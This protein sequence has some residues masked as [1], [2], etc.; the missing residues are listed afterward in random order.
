MDN[1]SEFVPYGTDPFDSPLLQN[2]IE[3][4]P[5]LVYL[6]NDEPNVLPQQQNDPVDVQQSNVPFPDS[7][8]QNQFVQDN[9][10]F[11][12]EGEIGNFEV[13]P[14]RRNGKEPLIQDQLMYGN[15]NFFN[16][17]GMG[18]FETGPWTQENQSQPANENMGLQN[19]EEVISLP[20]WPPI[21]RPFFCSCCHV[22]RQIVHTNGSKF[23][24][25]EIHGTIGVI[26]HAIIQIQ[27]I[28]PGGPSSDSHQMIDFCYRNAEQIKS[29]IVKYCAQQIE[30]G[31]IIVQDPLSAYYE[32]L[33]TG[34]DWAKDFSDEDD[35][36]IPRCRAEPEPEPEPENR[37]T[38]T[39]R[40]RHMGH[41]RKRIKRMTLSDLSGVFHIPIE[42][43]AYQLGV[44]LTVVKNICRRA[45]LE[46]WPHRKVVSNVKQVAVLRRG[47]DS[48]D[49][50]TR[51]TTRAEIQRLQEEIIERYNTGQSTPNFHNNPSDHHSSPGGGNFQRRLSP[52]NPSNHRLLLLEAIFGSSVLIFFLL[53]SPPSPFPPSS[54]AISL[55]STALSTV[56]FAIA[57]LIAV[58]ET[59]MYALIELESAFYSLAF[60]EDF[61][62]TLPFSPQTPLRFSP[63]YKKVSSKTK[64]V[65]IF[66]RRSSRDTTRLR[67]LREPL[68]LMERL[69]WHYVATVES[70]QVYLKRE[71][72]NHTGAHKINNAI[73]QAL[74][75]KRLGKRRVITESSA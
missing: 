65:S 57:M 17:R 40:R 66:C 6:S 59:L 55:V 1:N 61:S 25:L 38:S 16:R 58:L 2:F 44:C 10:N 63:N 21:P 5:A 74:L 11:P 31:Y 12:I 72:L 35:D 22:L 34:L 54:L 75:D 62:S 26:S 45:H 29:F 33:C 73:A 20:Y 41:Q 39:S 36:L 46:R 56:A 43:A 60:D 69:I 7:T 67:G 18:N 8:I 3:M 50:G 68:Y 52:N 70:L 47:L 71:D 53:F 30:L 9:N 23:E 51:E 37:R 13:A 15:N 48:P 49:P 27:N 32:A 14:S 24:K 19:Y 28:T 64:K 42:D 4:D